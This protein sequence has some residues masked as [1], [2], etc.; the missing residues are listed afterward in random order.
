MK[1]RDGKRTSLTSPEQQTMTNT[2]QEDE[3][4]TIQQ[5]EARIT[6][7]KET[8]LQSETTKIQDDERIKHLEEALQKAQPIYKL[9]KQL[10]QLHPKD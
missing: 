10:Q 7:L 8:A 1:L 3:Q 4:E 6:Q 5:L 2:D 9:S